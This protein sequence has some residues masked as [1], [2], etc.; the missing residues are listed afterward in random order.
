MAYDELFA[1]RIRHFLHEKKVSWREIK[2][3]GGL[4]MMVDEKM[5]VGVLHD[6]A[7]GNPLLMCR[8]GAPNMEDALKQPGCQPMD[9]TGRPLKG[10]V[11]V[12]PEGTDLDEDLE[13]WVQRCLDYTPLAR[14][15]KKSKKKR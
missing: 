2:M 7:T 3:M 12:T 6:K 8:V 14:S 9:F 1:D 15:S 10:F 4:C 11:F 5:C 13:H